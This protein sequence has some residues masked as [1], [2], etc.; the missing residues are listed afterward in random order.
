[1]AREEKIK[2]LYDMSI[3]MSDTL[4]EAYLTRLKLM[5]DDRLDKEYKKYILKGDM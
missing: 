2:Q 5:N 1:M 3:N 4:R